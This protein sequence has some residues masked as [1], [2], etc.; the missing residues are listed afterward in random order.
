MRCRDPVMLLHGRTDAPRLAPHREH[1]AR[2]GA[3]AT[4]DQRGHGDSEW[5]TDGAYAFTDFAADAP[6]SLRH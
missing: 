2:S 6:P 5:I 1:L 3:V 4:F